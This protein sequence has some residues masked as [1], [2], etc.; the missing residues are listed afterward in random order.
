[1]RP[2]H[3]S[4]QTL[5]RGR[6]VR[7]REGGR[8]WEEGKK[9]GGRKTRRGRGENKGKE[10]WIEGRTTRVGRGIETRREWNERKTKKK[11]DEG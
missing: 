6:R 7:G 3:A 4:V 10:E 9:V 5:G 11:M 1:M 2:D 8:G